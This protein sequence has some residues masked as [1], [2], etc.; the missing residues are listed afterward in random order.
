MQL[1]PI[2]TIHLILNHNIQPHK[3]YFERKFYTIEQYFLGIA[4]E[5]DRV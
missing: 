3:Q 5:F 4:Q 1:K 2:H